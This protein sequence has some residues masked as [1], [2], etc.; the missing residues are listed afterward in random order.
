MFK[1][2]LAEYGQGLAATF[3]VACKHLFHIIEKDIN[4]H[5]DRM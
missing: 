1:N 4:A 2:C 5:P 3:I